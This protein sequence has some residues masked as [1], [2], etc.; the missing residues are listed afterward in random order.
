M[1]YNKL[2]NACAFLA[3]MW[4]AF[5]H[6]DEKRAERLRGASLL[7]IRTKKMEIERIRPSAD[8]MSSCSDD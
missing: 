5:G 6:V 2:H 4:Q 1:W 3:I 7:G 8:D